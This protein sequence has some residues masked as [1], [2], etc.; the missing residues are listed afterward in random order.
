MA[1]DRDTLTALDTEF[2][3]AETPITPM[4][5]GGLSTYR[6]A[7]WLDAR[8]RIRI[9]PLR[10]HILAKLADVPRLHQRPVWPPGHAGRPHWVEDPGFDVRRHVHP[11]HLRAGST[12]DDLLDVAAELFRTQLDRRRPLWELWFIDGLSDGRAAVVEK[13]HHSLVDGIG[14]VDVAMMLLDLTPD[15]PLPAPPH[16]APADV[17]SPLALLADAARAAASEPFVL[18]RD[19]ASMAVHPLRT[20]G[21]AWRLGQAAA[22]V[23]GELVAP[24]SSLNRRV[25]THRFYRVVRRSLPDVR[26]AGRVLGGTVND[27]VLTAVT[28]GFHELFSVHDESLRG[29]PLH[30]LVPVSVRAAH[31]HQD[32]GNRVAAML[33]PLP[34]AETETRARFDEVL[35]EVRRAKRRHQV[36]LAAA[37][38]SA[39]DHMPEPLLAAMGR[40]VHHQPLVNVV[41]T[42]VPGPPVPLY[43]RGAECL[44]MFPLCPLARNTA[45]SVGILSYGD[46]LTLG[47][48][49]DSDRVPDLPLLIEAIEDSFDDLQKLAAGVTPVRA[50]AGRR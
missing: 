16:P 48:W 26:A 38:V 34:I 50:A 44:E 45:I 47:L 8:G 20:A 40:L 14:G 33:V 27:V 39:A 3:Y 13:I 17:R 24:R 1:G 35:R 41:V 23:A 9:G 19:V 5:V 36:E 43:L 32:L 21:R 28:A 11:L 18:G 2:L 30:A 22:S 4:H 37:V 25:G 7:P 29:A 42:N 46:A 12:D 49:G 10:T 6:A 15:A 31:E